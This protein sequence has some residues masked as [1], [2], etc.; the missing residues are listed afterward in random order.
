[1]HHHGSADHSGLIEGVLIIALVVSSGVHLGL[2]FFR[3][4][5]PVDGYLLGH[6]AMTA[7]MVWMLLPGSWIPAPPGGLAPFFG[8]GAAWFAVLL[9]R[10][11]RRTLWQGALRCG[12]LV[13]GYGAMAYMLSPA[14]LR[15]ALLTAGLIAYFL[16]L[17]F[18]AVSVILGQSLIIELPQEVS[19]AGAPSPAPSRLSRLVNGVS[20]PSAS[21]HAAMAVGMVYMLARLLA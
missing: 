4:G 17:G 14:D 16:L 19:G 7:G 8:L 11:C 21:A 20:T 15:W 10:H 2:R 9:A 18:G 13:V 5:H 3:R 1:M 12:D 6:G